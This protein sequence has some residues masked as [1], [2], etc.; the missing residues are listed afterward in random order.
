MTAEEMTT[1]TT[2]NIFVE[3]GICNFIWNQNI[4]IGA[5]GAQKIG[6]S[7]FNTKVVRIFTKI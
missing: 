1:K 5:I 6:L 2:T 7:T 4:L 3:Y